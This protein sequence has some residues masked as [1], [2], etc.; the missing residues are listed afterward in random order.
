MAYSRTTLKSSGDRALLVLDHFGRFYCTFHINTFYSARLVVWEPQTLWEYCTILLS[1]LNHSL[2]WNLWI[3]DVLSHGTPTFPPVSGKCKNLSSSWPVTSKPTVTIPNNFI[4]MWMD[5]YCIV[6]SM[7]LIAIISCD[8][9]YS[10][11]HY[12]S[13]KLV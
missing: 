2:P 3:A 8:N 4:Y 5:G 7:K 1:S 9:Y 12:L 6:F 11:F 10:H 13:C